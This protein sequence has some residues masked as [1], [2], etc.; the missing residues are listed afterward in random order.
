[1]RLVALAAEG[2]RIYA[3]IWAKGDELTAATRSVSGAD[4]VV[5]AIYVVIAQA[6]DLCDEIAS[7]RAR[8]EGYAGT[9][10]AA[11]Q[12]VDRAVGEATGLASQ[13]PNL[14]NPARID[15]LYRAAE[16]LAG[17]LGA[18]VQMLRADHARLLQL[19]ASYR[20]LDL[21][22]A[23]GDVATMS[24]QVN[25][26]LSAAQ[27][28]AAQIA[29]RA[30]RLQVLVGEIDALRNTTLVQV[31][32]LML[33]WPADDGPEIE[34]HVSRIPTSFGDVS[35]HQASAGIAVE[36]LTY[37]QDLI[38]VATAELDGA[39]CPNLDTADGVVA[40]AENAYTGALI[41]VGA[42]A[43]LPQKAAACATAVA[44]AGG[45][46][47]PQDAGWGA[48]GDS[49]VQDR[50][51]EPTWEQP[52]VGVSDRPPAVPSE[53][54]WGQPGTGVVDVPQPAGGDAPPPGAYPPSVASPAPGTYPPPS[55]GYPPPSAYPPPSVGYPPPAMYPPPTVVY[56]PPQPRQPLPPPQPGFSPGPQRP[57]GGRVAVAPPPSQPS[58]SRPPAGSAQ[59]CD[60]YWAQMRTVMNEQQRLLAQAQSAARDPRREGEARRLSC[61]MVTN[62]NKALNVLQQARGAGCPVQANLESVVRQWQASG[63][64]R[65]CS[66]R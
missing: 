21:A 37:A 50:P 7:L 49:A 53:A 22:G 29:A 51:P 55:V 54:G 4:S 3:E 15:S 20:G 26:A 30:Q 40:A 63:W 6:K 48:G 14:P 46:A 43:D 58:P 27:D 33:V 39:A 24:A 38:A 52:G 57:T 8:I 44:S 42:G 2:D 31:R 17:Q 65:M 36:G 34:A 59:V 16:G 32:R 64:Q 13:C 18:D 5:S 45:G 12:Q 19:V 47:R 66:G 9:A 56:P 35:V 10:A 25:Q 61:Q 23:R 1:M 28:G 11:E 60:P 62:T 41:H